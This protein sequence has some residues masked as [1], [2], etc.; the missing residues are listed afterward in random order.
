LASGAARL[1]DAEPSG[2]PLAASDRTPSRLNT[3]P[4]GVWPSRRCRS[5]GWALWVCV[6]GGPLG[7]RRIPT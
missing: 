3:R 7:P 1:A 2:S 4:C 6:L 5:V